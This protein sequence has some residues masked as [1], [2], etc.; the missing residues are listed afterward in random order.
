V[1]AAQGRSYFFRSEASSPKSLSEGPHDASRSGGGDSVY[2][3]SSGKGEG[4]MVADEKER[5]NENQG[6]FLS[7]ETQVFKGSGHAGLIL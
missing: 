6:E 4:A 2:F 7:F 3:V 1:R 5:N